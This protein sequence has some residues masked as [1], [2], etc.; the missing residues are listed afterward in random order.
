MN[1]RI[2]EAKKVELIRRSVRDVQM[3]AEEQETLRKMKSRAYEGVKS[4]IARNIKVIDKVNRDRGYISP[5]RLRTNSAS[6][7]MP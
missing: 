5:H 2:S 3:R 4:K 1:Q 7:L 6:Q